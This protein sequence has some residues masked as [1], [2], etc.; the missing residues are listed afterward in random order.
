MGDVIHVEFGNKAREDKAFNPKPQDIDCFTEHEKASIT[1][2]FQ[3]GEQAGLFSLLEPHDL[4]LGFSYVFQGID[5]KGAK[6]PLVIIA[7]APHPGQENAFTYLAQYETFE[8]NGR[9]AGPLLLKTQFFGTI[10]SWLQRAITNNLITPPS[11]SEEGFTIPVM[12]PDQ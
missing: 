8:E 10:E 11:C 12:S 5:S 2:L 1:A 3:A 6:A 9:Y 7:K 4:N